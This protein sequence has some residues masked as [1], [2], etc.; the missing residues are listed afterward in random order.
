[1]LKHCQ[2]KNHT[3]QSSTVKEDFLHGYW[4][5]GEG[6]ELPLN[7]IPLRGKVGG[8]LSPGVS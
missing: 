7:S 6:T 1:M 5:S 8:F 3:E 4:K 2:N